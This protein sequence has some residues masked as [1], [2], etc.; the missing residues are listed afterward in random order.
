MK[1]SNLY[2]VHTDIQHINAS[3]VFK[4]PAFEFSTPSLSPSISTLV[5][6]ALHNALQLHNRNLG[7]GSSWEIYSETA[8]GSRVSQSPRSLTI[9][10]CSL[11]AE[12]LLFTTTTACLKKVLAGIWSPL[13]SPFLKHHSASVCTIC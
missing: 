6:G 1:H 3:E 11:E 5:C 9:F 10:P 7:I 13:G 8:A 4:L 2:T 12:S